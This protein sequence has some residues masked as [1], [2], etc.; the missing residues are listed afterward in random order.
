MT[1]D[2]LTASAISPTMEL[3]AAFSNAW[4]E[5]WAAFRLPIAALRSECEFPF[6]CAECDD[7]P[8][9]AS[10]PTAWPWPVPPC[11][12]AEPL[13]PGPLPP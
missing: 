8:L 13:L 5:A 3:A 11:P 7:T 9:T 1:N 10:C 4:A 6:I 2:S 12:G